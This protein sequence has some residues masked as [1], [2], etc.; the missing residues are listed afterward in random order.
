MLSLGQK[1]QISL[2]L[3]YEYVNKKLTQRDF[4]D[5]KKSIEDLITIQGE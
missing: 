5:F 2:I 1:L 3:Y 4:E